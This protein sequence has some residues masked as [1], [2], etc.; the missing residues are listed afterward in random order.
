MRKI[1]IAMAVAF[2]LGLGVSPASAF[3]PERYL[4]CKAPREQPQPEQEPTTASAKAALVPLPSSRPRVLR[5]APLVVADVATR[6]P[7]PSGH[8]SPEAPEEKARPVVRSSANDFRCLGLTRG[9]RGIVRVVATHPRAR[10]REHPFADSWIIDNLEA[11][12]KYHVVSALEGARL[13]FRRPIPEDLE[14]WEVLSRLRLKVAAVMA[15]AELGDTASASAIRDFARERE[16]KDYPGHWEDTVRA[17]E[18]L[19]PALFQAYA[20]E[21]IERAAQSQGHDTGEQNRVLLLAPKLRGPDVRAAAALTKLQPELDPQNNGGGFESCQV[22]AARVRTGGDGAERALRDTLR[23]EVATDLRTNRGAVCYSQI[24]AAAFPGDSPDEVPT[25]LYRHRY[26]S[27][28]ALVARMAKDDRGGTKDPRHDKARDEIRAWLVKRAQDPDIKLDRSDRR[29][30]DVT[31]VKH[32]A[33]AAKLG[34]AA[35]AKELEQSILEPKD[36]EVA[37]WIGARAALDLEL[38]F[39]REAAVKRLLLAR[40]VPLDR[41]VSESWPTRGLLTVTEEVDVV[42][43]LRALGDSRFSLGALSRELWTREAT[44]HAIARA[45]PAER[46]AICRA[47]TS[48]AKDAEEKAVQDAFWGLSTLGPTCRDDFAR[49]YADTSQPDHVRGMALEALAM[50]RDSV[51]G[52]EV[53][54][55]R[56]E[57]FRTARQRAAI[58]VADP[59]E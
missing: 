12:G 58:I 7:T 33:L 6:E 47:V 52:P 32:L 44:L 31:R 53:R 9:E 45:T 42:D 35:A 39:A 13:A 14:P 37:P 51:V 3:I 40:Q 24:V 26:D 30:S 8:R 49:L 1:A 16:S 48:A 23:G 22:Y 55:E 43:R 34:D 25:L 50:L 38:P 15:L 28:L 59:T 17:L 10:F 19:D 20:V 4:V 36:D 56:R 41:H 29:F 57:P 5:A 2:A 11:A 27:L 21:V 46:P 54:D 18:L